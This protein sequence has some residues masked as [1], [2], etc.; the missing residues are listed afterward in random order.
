M[1]TWG[2]AFKF[3]I[4]TPKISL[5]PKNVPDYLPV[6]HVD[7]NAIKTVSFIIRKY[8]ADLV[9]VEWL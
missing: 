8:Y 7:I 1:G 3:L 2:Q 9:N 5:H 4:C 6:S